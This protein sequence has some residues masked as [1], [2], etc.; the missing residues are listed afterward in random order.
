MASENSTEEKKVLNV[1]IWETEV[2][3]DEDG[4]ESLRPIKPVYELSLQ[5]AAQV[6][7]CTLRT[8][9]ELLR[10]GHLTGHDNGK[11]PKLSYGRTIHPRI[12]IDASSVVEY[13]QPQW[14]ADKGL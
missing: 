11:A 2:T 1:M 10:Q 7:G 4:R 13:C 14:R 5:K 8:V 3:R 9:K 12:K 6:I